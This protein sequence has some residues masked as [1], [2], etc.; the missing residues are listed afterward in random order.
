MNL[1]ISWQGAFQKTEISLRKRPSRQQEDK[2]TGCRSDSLIAL[3]VRIP[4]AL[5]LVASGRCPEKEAL[6]KRF[7]VLAVNS[8]GQEGHCQH[9]ATFQ[10]SH[11]NLT[12]GGNSYTPQFIDCL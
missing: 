3:T 5:D 9:H 10:S 7:Q 6:R 1:S 4:G 12:V 2:R 8:H 11:R